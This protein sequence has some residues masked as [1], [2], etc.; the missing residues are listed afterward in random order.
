M[1]MDYYLIIIIIIT[2]VV[3]IITITSNDVLTSKLSECCYG[4]EYCNANVPAPLWD[5]NVHMEIWL[6][7]KCFV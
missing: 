5:R 6:K 3:T 1:K 2:I 7:V 4:S